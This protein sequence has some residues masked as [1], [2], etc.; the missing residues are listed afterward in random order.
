MPNPAILCLHGSGV[1]STIFKF[2][3]ATLQSLLSQTFDF[4]FIDGPFETPAGY[5]VLPFFAGAEPFFRWKSKTDDNIF[6]HEEIEPKVQELIKKT[7][8]SRDDWIGILGFSQGGRLAAGLIAEQ[9]R[10]EEETGEDEGG[11]KFGVFLNTP[12]PPMTELVYEKD[13]EVRIQTPSLLVRGVRD[14]WF[15]SSGVM[16]EKYFEEEMS[17]MVE[18][19]VDHRIPNSLDDVKVIAR[20]IL[21]LYL[22]VTGIRGTLNK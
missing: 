10:K 4:I 19:D 9:E 12:S 18:F 3:L 14:H 17:K 7:L 16:R 13:A 8:K 15:E 6:S 2:Q 22:E 20:E 11:F 21:R 5:G 1:N